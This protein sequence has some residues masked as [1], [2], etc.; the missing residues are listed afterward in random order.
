MKR[1]EGVGVTELEY[2][3]YIFLVYCKVKFYFFFLLFMRV[4]E[5]MEGDNSVYL[6]SV[7]E[8]KK[9]ILFK[10]KGCIKVVVS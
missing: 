3:Y 10:F 9:S 2:Y 7:L 1:E 5:Q 8:S 4:S 6:K